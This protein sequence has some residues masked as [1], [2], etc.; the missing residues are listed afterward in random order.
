M[1][2]LAPFESFVTRQ[3][4]IEWGQCDP[5]GIVFAPRYLDMVTEN[6]ILLFEVAGLPPKKTMLDSEAS[7]GYPMV[8]VSARFFRP[9]T[10]GDVVT[11]ETA[12][13]AFGSS[14]FT[15][16]HRIIFEGRLCVEVTEKRVWTIKD[17][18][19]PGGLRAERVPDAVRA[20]F[21]KD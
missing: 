10:F 15:I 17:A 21:T 13:P 16:E 20:L 1:A 6:T 19:R 14:S 11:I 18:T 12:A 3:H 4:R 5:A 7:A 8:D 2:E 9:T